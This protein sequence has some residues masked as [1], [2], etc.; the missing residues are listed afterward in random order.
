MISFDN[1]SYY[2]TNSRVLRILDLKQ[3]YIEEFWLDV[4]LDYPERFYKNLHLPRNAIQ[5]VTRSYEG[6]NADEL[7]KEFMQY[8]N[9]PFLIS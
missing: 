3:N 7:L 8:F 6:V 2:L 5:F 9:R 4:K 1:F